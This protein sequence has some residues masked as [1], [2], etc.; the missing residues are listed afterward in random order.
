MTSSDA[1]RDADNSSTLQELD[2]SRQ[3]IMK[4]VV[5]NVSRVTSQLFILNVPPNTAM[6]TDH[7]LL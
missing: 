5:C 2:V 4:T 1:A 6:S 7:C 3:L